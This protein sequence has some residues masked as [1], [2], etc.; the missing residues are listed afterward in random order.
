[1]RRQ[2]HW[3]S[4]FLLAAMSSSAA[5]DSLD[6]NLH[7]EA[8][9]AT[10]AVIPPAKRGVEVEVGHYFNEDDQYVSHAGMHVSGENWSKRGVF[11]LGLGGRLIY[12]NT[13]PL[14]AGA[15]AI[16]ARLRFSPV[17]RVGLGASVYY[18]PQIVTFLDG[19]NYS[20]VS[21]NLDYQLLPQAFVYVGYRNIELDFEGVRDVELD[22]KV[23]VGMKLL[24]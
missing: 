24:F 1:M 22:D 4:A 17:Q 7:D 2:W 19:E 15:L 5:A 9:R 10:Y 21:V 13:D 16:G 11:E 14:D 23:H 3:A 6:I 18:A 20:E 8:L 12:V